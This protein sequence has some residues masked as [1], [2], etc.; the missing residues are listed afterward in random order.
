MLKYVKESTYG[1]KL[2][3]AP[4]ALIFKKPTITQKIVVDISNSECFC[5]S[6]RK[7]RKC[8]KFLFLPVEKECH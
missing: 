7:C 5:R 1:L 3:M 2:S 4:T 6:D 8:G